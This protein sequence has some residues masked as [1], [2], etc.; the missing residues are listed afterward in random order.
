MSLFSPMCVW[1]VVV[2]LGL[3]IQREQYELAATAEEGLGSL[4]DGTSESD[5]DEAKIDD[6]AGALVCVCVCVV[7]VCVFVVFGTDG[8]FIADTEGVIAFFN[9]NDKYG[10]L[11]T[12]KLS[13]DVY[14]NASQLAFPFEEAVINARVLYTLSSNE[15]G[16]I[17]KA[18]RLVKSAKASTLEELLQKAST[19]SVKELQRQTVMHVKAYTNI[20]SV[21]TAH[22]SL[23]GSCCSLCP[24]FC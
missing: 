3:E 7:F 11:R 1:W 19:I 2:E 18:V 10:F 23:K 14:F 22:S 13:R 24:T 9:P 15:R 6:K 21:S 5:S 12:A 8:F 17:A 16:Y 4:D 20:E